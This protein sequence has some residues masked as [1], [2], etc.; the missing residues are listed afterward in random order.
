MNAEFPMLVYVIERPG[1]PIVIDTGMHA[2]GCSVSFM[3]R[4][5]MPSAVI[6]GEQVLFEH[7]AHGKHDSP[8]GGAT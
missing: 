7:P 1:G 6:E 3:M 2:E 4:R 5:M 8:T